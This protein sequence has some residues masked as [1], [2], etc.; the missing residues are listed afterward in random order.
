MNFVKKLMADERFRRFS[1]F[2]YLTGT[3]GFVLGSLLFWGPIRWTVNYLQEEGYA[4][5]TESLVIKIYI[6]IILLLAGGIAYYYTRRFWESEN[7]KKKYGLFIP[8]FFFGAV[9]F[10]WMNPQYTP[11]RGERSENIV[12]SR[13]SFVFRPYPSET[14]IMQLKK[15]HYAGIISLLHPAVVPFEPKLIA[16]EDAAAKQA[17]I[18]VIHAPMLPWVSQNLSSIEKIKNLLATGKGKY[19]V[20]CYLGKDR[21]NVVRRIIESQNVSTDA[22]NITAYR[23]LNEIKMFAGGP[24]F[25]LGKA[26]YLLP[27]PTEEECLGYLLT[28]YVKQVVSLVDDATAENRELA[29]KDSTLYATYAMEYAHI[30]FDLKEFNYSKLK[31]ILDSLHSAAKPL[32]LLLASTKDER[33]SM[34]VQAITSY[35]SINQTEVEK[36]F[37]EKN[38]FRMFP[39]IYVGPEPDEAQIKGLV[40]NGI[41]SFV[42]TGK[43][44]PAMGSTGNSE[45][46]YYLLPANGKLDS[47]LAKGKWYIFNVTQSELEKRFSFH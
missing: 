7:P 14:Q 6:V 40:E 41:T 17:G 46:K 4:D 37:P 34:L 32:V 12:L 38:I 26:V 1:L 45:I 8:L 18:E 42:S 13:I 10:L 25:Y 29:K 47:L 24:L 28:G 11:G 39:N 21:V 35:F 36:L 43:K 5:T 30:P 23:T 9:L 2:T 33:T 16:D 27:R 15:E 31:T 22:S 19:Y 20:H 3:M 44:T